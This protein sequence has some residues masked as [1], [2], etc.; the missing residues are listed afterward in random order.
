MCRKTILNVPKRSKLALLLTSNSFHCTDEKDEKGPLAPSRKSVS[1]TVAVCVG[2]LILSEQIHRYVITTYMQDLHP[3][4]ESERHRHILARHIGVDAL[5]CGIIAYLGI[6]NRH[7]LYEICTFKRDK[8]MNSEQSSHSRI[9]SYQ[10]E[11]HRVLL[12]FL[13][14]QVKNIHDSW[15]WDDG[16]IFIA[17]HIFAGMTAWFGMYP[18]V[19]SLY[20]L[21]FMGISEISTC[22]LCL[23]SNF[24]PHFGVSGLDQVFPNTKI[25]LGVLFVVLFIICRVCLWPMF[26]YHFLLDSMKVLKRNSPKETKEVKFALKMM[27]GSNVFLTTLQVA[28]LGEIIMTAKEEISALL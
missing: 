16:L 18:G 24:D 20:G 27:M 25:V 8:E 2:L 6:V 14:Y 15:Y 9:Y 4:L 7:I 3:I 5:S 19:A 26:S 21:F 12:F 22:V 13:A 1:L 23:L 11:A 28:W 17:H 10:P